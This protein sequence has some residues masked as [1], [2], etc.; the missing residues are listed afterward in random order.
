MMQNN[1][2]TLIVRNLFYSTEEV[3]SL[4]NMSLTSFRGERD[5]MFWDWD[6]G[7]IISLGLEAGDQL[8]ESLFPVSLFNT[9]IQKSQSTK[10]SAQFHCHV[11]TLGI[12]SLSLKVELVCEKCENCGHWFVQ[13]SKKI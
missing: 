8:I 6:L 1:W 4:L 3:I 13:L 2:D 7:G 10:V 9:T 12:K 11:L 5:F